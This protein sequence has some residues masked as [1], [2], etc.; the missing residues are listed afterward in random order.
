MVVKSSKDF[1]L[2]SGAYGSQNWNKNQQQNQ[3]QV[4][5]NNSINKV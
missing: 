1:S 3:Q 5:N 4:L 2:T